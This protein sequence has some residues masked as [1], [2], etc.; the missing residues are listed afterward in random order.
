MRLNFTLLITRFRDI[1]VCDALNM[2]CGTFNAASAF[3]TIDGTRKQ[4]ADLYDEPEILML[5]AVELEVQFFGGPS[6]ARWWDGNLMMMLID[7]LLFAYAHK[8]I[9]LVHEVL[10]TVV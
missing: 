10:K 8:Q 5:P 3:I 7:H 4:L 2:L 6:P 9:H 1:T